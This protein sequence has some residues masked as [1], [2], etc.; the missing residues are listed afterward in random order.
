MT[1]FAIGC[2]AMSEQDLSKVD[3]RIMKF[4]TG[5]NIIE[6]YEGKPVSLPDYIPI[7]YYEDS[8]NQEKQLTLWCGWKGT[9]PQDSG[10]YDQ[11][12]II[13]LRIDGPAFSDLTQDSVD[14]EFLKSGG[15]PMEVYF[16]GN[17]VTNFTETAQVTYSCPG[18]L[19]SGPT[20][21]SVPFTYTN[22]YQTVGNMS[23]FL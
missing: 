11:E 13:N 7:N 1:N 16:K 10:Q 23:Q 2:P 17:L 12:V 5:W 6:Q 20:T 18:G 8:D 3:P 15:A 4:L 14:A 9:P 19:F 21:G 22:G